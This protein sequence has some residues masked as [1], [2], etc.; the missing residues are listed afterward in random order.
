MT[1]DH[2]LKSIEA[3]ALNMARLATRND[4]DALDL[5]QDAMIKLASS[6]G[7]RQPEEWRPLFLKI[8][9]NGILDWHRKEKLKRALF[10][11]RHEETDD[12]DQ[13]VDEFELV[14]DPDGHDPLHQMEAEQTQQQLLACIADLPIRQ[15]QCFLL[16]CWEGLSVQ[17]TA[18]IMGLNEG[19]VKTHYS[20][21]LDKL[22][23]IRQETAQ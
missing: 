11:W 15:Q 14:A 17:D 19:S 10:F 2:F 12:T 20:R 22:H 21:A 3:R 9:E 4:D 1:L 13:G 18:R 8:L 6:Y 5:V 7:Q 16:R 23:A